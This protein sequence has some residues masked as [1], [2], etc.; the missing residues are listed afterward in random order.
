M[1]TIPARR[2]VKVPPPYGVFLKKGTKLKLTVALH[3]V[4][5][6]RDLPYKDVRVSLVG[7]IAEGR[8]KN[9]NYRFL[10]IGGCD[11]HK[12]VFSIPPQSAHIHYSMK[13][14]YIFPRKGTIVRL[15]S[16]YHAAKI[17]GIQST[18]RFYLNDN[19][20]K[21]FSTAHSADANERNPSFAFLPPVPVN[22]GNRLWPKGILN[23]PADVAEDE[24]MVMGG[25]FFT[26]KED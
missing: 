11:F 10:S 25:V 21:E 26:Q 22:A 24:A 23:N 5:T 2:G 8:T 4:E 19:I 7:E 6:K 17:P 20:L 18:I 13:I 3:R 15:G 9:L 14:P 12:G 16:H 1:G